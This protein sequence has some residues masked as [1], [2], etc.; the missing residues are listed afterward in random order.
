M[1][2]AGILGL[3]SAI[4]KATGHSCE[5]T[6]VENLKNTLRKMTQAISFSQQITKRIN[7][8]VVYLFKVTDGMNT[9]LES[10]SY[11]LKMVDKT[12]SVWSRK[13]R[14][15]SNTVR[16]HESLMME[17]LSKYSTEVGRAFSSITRLFEIQDTVNQI[18]R[19]NH[20][21]LIGFSELPNFMTS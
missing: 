19:M 17:F 3:F 4:Y 11:N 21:S 6:H 10:L 8:N 9:R 18:S 15:F 13:L 2:H 5:S 7:G 12:F 20:R 14:K 1:C 16:C